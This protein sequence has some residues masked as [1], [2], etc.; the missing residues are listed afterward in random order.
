[1]SFG[2]RALVIEDGRVF[3]VR[4]S[5]VPGWYLPGGGVEAGE[6]A[7]AAMAR[8]LREEAGLA[9]GTA[10]LFGLYLNARVSRRDHVA[11]YVVERFTPIPGATLPGREI[12]ERGFF[13]LDAL[14]VETTGATR[15]RIAE[16]T[17]GLAPA[18][19]W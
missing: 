15:R 5:Y 10:R 11:L 1:M 18:E 16:V 7:P 9:A 17:G 12:V 8:E 4:H 13:A 2:V 19:I 6:T 3:L 14:P